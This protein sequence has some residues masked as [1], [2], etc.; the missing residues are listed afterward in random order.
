MGLLGFS[1]CCPRLRTRQK[2]D[3]PVDT[4]RIPGIDTLRRKP[5]LPPVKLMY[6]V[7]PARYEV[8]DLPEK[9]KEQ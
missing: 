7:P 9:G 5:E 4:L 2:T 1:S 3:V 6:G 8:L